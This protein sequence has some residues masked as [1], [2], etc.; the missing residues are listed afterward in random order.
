MLFRSSPDDN[1]GFAH[2]SA[3]Y[4]VDPAGSLVKV[5]DYEDVDGAAE[6]VVG[7]LVKG[8]GGTSL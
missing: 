6:K 4:L 1:G 5:M 7:V 2:N 8:E 3:F